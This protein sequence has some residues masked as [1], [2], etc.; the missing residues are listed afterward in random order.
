MIQNKRCI[1]GLTFRKT[2]DSI[3]MSPS[4][5]STIWISKMKRSTASSFSDPINFRLKRRQKNSLQHTYSEMPTRTSVRRA[6][7][8]L[9]LF[10]DSKKKTRHSSSLRETENP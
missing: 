2:M 1:Q 9:E 8:F 10:L 3:T 7:Y 5:N 6:F 4:T